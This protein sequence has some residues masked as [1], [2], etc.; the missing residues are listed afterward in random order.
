MKNL[1]TKAKTKIVLSRTHRVFIFFLLLTIELAINN[2]T[3]LLSSAS[4]NIKE[5]LN[6]NDKGFGMF[7][8]M[9]GL[10]RVIGSFVFLFIVNKFNR[11]FI[12]ALFVIVKG[13]LSMCFKLTKI[14]QI[15]ISTRFFIGITHMPPNTYVPIWIDQFGIQHYKTIFMTLMQVAYPVGKV[16][17]YVLHMIFGEDQW[18]NGFVF[19]G[20]YLVTGGLII[21]MLPSKYFSANLFV[22]KSN[23]GDGEEV[24]VKIQN[25]P[26]ESL[27]ETGE[28]FVSLLDKNKTNNKNKHNVG[29]GYK[30]ILTN[31]VFINGLIIRAILYGINSS[32]HYWISDYIRNV[33][34][35]N[36]NKLI[37][38]SYTIIAIVGPLGGIVISSLVNYWLGGYE[39]RHS[40][41]MLFVLHIIASFCGI[42]IPLVNSLYPFS[43][44]VVLYLI[45]NSATLPILQGL[46]ITSVS[47]NLKGTAFSIANL[48][49]MLLTS[50]PAP[51][52]YGIINDKYK[53]VYPKLGMF[54]TMSC[55]FV[56][57]VFFV[58]LI[59]GKY[60]AAIKTQDKVDKQ[61]SNNDTLM[62][63]S[64]SMLD[65][66]ELDNEEDV[67]MALKS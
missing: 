66:D 4:K 20:I 3:G 52:V 37:F 50:G 27:F 42:A 28:S 32:L 9:S 17:G 51:V 41:I 40:V 25:I 45:F 53:S 14:S 34:L 64:K 7:G 47:P 39:H 59:I 29:K 61:T 55:S 11:K 65:V 10:G 33:L 35:I 2:S 8:T 1:Q 31:P 46:I 60:R 24:K 13:L 38:V 12:L 57:F 44:S 23:K 43:I 63:Q 58:G 62:E 56:A 49:T 21:M 15:L 36:N 22:V 30:E 48:V 6:L 18:Q 67:E 54:S 5:S 19:E 16:I 26:T